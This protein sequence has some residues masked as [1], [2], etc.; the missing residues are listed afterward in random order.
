MFKTT[1]FASALVATVSAWENMAAANNFTTEAYG[2]DNGNYGHQGWGKQAGYGAAYGAQD[3]MSGFGRTHG[4]VDVIGNNEWAVADNHNSY[5]QT[6]HQGQGHN[7]W[8][9]NAWNQWGVNNHFDT[10]KS[11]DNKWGNNSGKVNVNINSVSGHYDHD[12]GQ[13][14]RGLGY[15]GH[16]NV[17]GEVG[18]E[19][20]MGGHS[21]GYEAGDHSYGYENNKDWG[22][23]GWANNLGAWNHGAN[24]D[25]F[26][27]QFRDSAR[28]I[29]NDVTDT[30][31]IK[32]N[33]RVGSGYA[34]LEE[35]DQYD[36]RQDQYGSVRVGRTGAFRGIGR[37]GGIF[38]A[39]EFGEFGAAGARFGLGPR[40]GGSDPAL[41]DVEVRNNDRIR[42]AGDGVRVAQW[43]GRDDSYAESDN[44]ISGFKGAEYQ[45]SGRYGAGYSYGGLDRLGGG[46]YGAPYGDRYGY[47]SG[48][49]AG[50]SG[51]GS[52]IRDSI[53]YGGAQNYEDDRDYRFGG[54]YGY[55]QAGYGGRYGVVSGDRYGASYGGRYG[56][57]YGDRYGSA[58][59][60]KSYG[61]G[62]YDGEDNYGY[63]GKRLNSAYDYDNGEIGYGGY[64]ESLGNRSHVSPTRYNGW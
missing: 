38:G 28:D 15:E 40:F 5:R 43:G 24:Y 42:S 46:R 22:Y 11:V 58:Y 18:Y 44:V 17:S 62:E 61:L 36:A 14:Q 8:T 64:R 27:N 3:N 53:S 20:G 25:N 51:Y 41:A 45:G 33:R 26:G 54:A 23:G 63:D 6:G 31:D 7:Q 12:Y 47:N 57:A 59:G 48:Y 35:L 2:V 10:Q 13:Q 49:G 4:G 21:F 1:L 16:Q 56:G 29:T 52:N 32:E 9:D 30:H 50:Y 19:L 60:S 34:D 37:D 39:A 55:N